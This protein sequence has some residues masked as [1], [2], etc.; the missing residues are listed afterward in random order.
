M[1]RNRIVVICVQRPCEESEVFCAL[2]AGALREY[3]DRV[4]AGESGAETHESMNSENGCLVTIAAG[5]C[6]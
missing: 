2:V 3:A 4:A 5:E 6:V 1:K